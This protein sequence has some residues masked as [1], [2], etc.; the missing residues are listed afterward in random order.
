MIPQLF[1]STAPAYRPQQFAGLADRAQA[2]VWQEVG[3][4]GGE[5]KNYARQQQNR[6]DVLAASRAWRSLDDWRLKYLQGLPARRKDLAATSLDEESGSNVTGYERELKTFP[7]SLNAEYDR[8]AE[9][10][11]AQA[12]AMLEERFNLHA[13]GWSNQAV[14][15]LEGLE[16]EDVTSEILDLAGQ[17][18]VSDAG[19]LL[20][21][22]ADRYSPGD[23]DDL[24]VRIAQAGVAA[25]VHAVQGYLQ[26]VAR[27]SGWEAASKLLDDPE[28]QK[29]W[30]L[31]VDEAG[32]LKTD[33]NKFV[34]DAK[35]LD[36]AK[37]KAAKESANDAMIGEA[38]KGTLDL[39]T[40]WDRVG[41]DG[42][43][44]AIALQAKE[45]ML[46]KAQGLE[47]DDVDVLSEGYSWLR[48]VREDPTKRAEALAYVR[49][50][51]ASLTE[52]SRK[53]LIR[54]LQLAGSTEDPSS[55]VG[56]K[57]AN[58]LIDDHYEIGT[59]GKIGT[60]DAQKGYLDV[61]QE[62]DR[63]S[64]ENPNATNAEIT[65]EYQALF[66]STI[67]PAAWKQALSG[68]W[69]YATFYGLMGQLSQAAL[70]SPVGEAA[71]P[72]KSG[73]WGP[74]A[75]IR[76]FAD[77]PELLPTYKIADPDIEPL[78]QQEFEDTYI[79]L[80]EGS[81]QADKYYEKWASKWR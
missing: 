26:D 70:A 55:R 27:Q 33:L 31:D 47:K 25:R 61:K 21:Q 34:N 59:F 6:S 29:D 77:F 17:D 56:V 38:D 48:R 1:R 20:D 52:G 51:A 16:T 12:R 67:K 80:P 39:S 5:I 44:R 14:T 46:K 40:L 54:D 78:S 7:D 62:F 43:D 63:W 13:P 64:R 42:A 79:S 23:L 45:I 73:A 35:T 66:A 69:K 24:R 9:G 2:G 18:R 41:P 28:F 71:G 75:A 81:P 30:G 36:E 57:T 65:A 32:N 60:P 68:F 19:E 10:L 50:H 37:Q 49:G 76:A 3:Q 74:E 53:E 58:K 11:S 15:A 8:L 72:R 4:L 22:Y